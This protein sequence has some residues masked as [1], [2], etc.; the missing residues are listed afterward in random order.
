MNTRILHIY[1][2]DYAPSSFEKALEDGK[3]SKEQLWEDSWN[4]GAPVAVKDNTFHA[5]ALQFGDVDPK[6]IRF[7][8]DDIVRERSEDAD[9][10][11]I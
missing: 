10:Y 9:F 11:I 5:K 1:G 8:R 6:F 4:T 7:V 3:I 2:G